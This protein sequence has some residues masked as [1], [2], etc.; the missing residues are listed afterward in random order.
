MSIPVTIYG[1]FLSAHAP[2]LS[3]ANCGPDILGVSYG[4]F[5]I[6]TSLFW[7]VLGKFVPVAFSSL[8]PVALA[9]WVGLLV[10]AIN[11]LPAGQLDGGHV[12]RALLGDRSRYV[13][14]AA[15]VLLLGIGVF[16]YQ[17]W[18][19]FAILILFLGMR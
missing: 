4:N 1:M 6:G 5:V 18:I 15:V 8:H 19:I 13:S 14:Y 11:L 7:F 10:T 17:G 16:L 3:A 12:F 2:I 9:G